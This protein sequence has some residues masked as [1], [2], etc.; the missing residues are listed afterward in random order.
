[1]KFRLRVIS[2][3]LWNMQIGVDGDRRPQVVP[4][5]EDA[6]MKTLF[7]IDEMELTHGEDRPSDVQR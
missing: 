4:L 7:I 3:Q 1:M 5:G 2:G 6:G